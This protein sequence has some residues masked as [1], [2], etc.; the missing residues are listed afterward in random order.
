MGQA[1]KRGT[2]EE[3]IT[4][5]LGLGQRNLNDIKR[6][7]G[8]PLN[9]EF[10]GY[11]VHLESSDEFIMQFEDNEEATKKTWVKTPEI[12]K[13]YTS[14]IDA[15]DVS[16]KCPGSIVVGIFDGEK[17]IWVASVV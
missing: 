7:A 5:K 12:A 3:R 17:Q 2:R 14:F 10:L 9:T 15:Y 13:T 1:N 4:K 8:I 6:E 11:S 16:Q